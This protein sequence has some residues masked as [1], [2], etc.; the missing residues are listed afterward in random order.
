M[1]GVCLNSWQTHGCEWSVG[2]VWRW[3]NWILRL[4]VIVLALM[5]AYVLVVVTRV[6]Y[7]HYLAR[8]EMGIDNANGK[9]LIAVLRTGAVSLKSIALAA[10]YVG[11]AGTCVAMGN[12]N[13]QKEIANA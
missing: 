2:Y 8:R 3:M 12:V 5:L 7:L 9:N 6:A 10:P 1:N 11:L 4:D 13:G